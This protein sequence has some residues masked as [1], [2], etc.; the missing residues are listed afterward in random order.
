[1]VTSMFAACSKTAAPAPAAPAAPATPAAPAQPAA[2]DSG[3]FAGVT[4]LATPTNLSIG[5]LSGSNHGFMTYLIDKLGGYKQVG[6]TPKFTLFG[7]GPV[8]IEA[9]SSWD[10]GASGIGG[11]LAG[12]I[13]YGMYVIGETMHDNGTLQFFAPNDSPIVKAGQTISDTPGLYGTAE[14]WKGAEI[15]LPRGTTLEYAL[16]KGL[17]KFGLTEADVKLTQMDVSNV[18]TALMAGKCPVGG[19]FNNLPYAPDLNKLAKPVMKAT[20]LGVNLQACLFANPTAYNDPVKFEAIKKTVELYYKGIDWIYA[21]DANMNQ[22]CQWFLE[23]NQANGVKSTLYDCTQDL[24]DPGNKYFTLKEN[25][26]MY[27]QKSADG[28][29]TLAEQ[30]NYEPLMFFINAG[31]YKTTDADKFLGGY[32]KSEI[33]ES[34]YNKK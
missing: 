24:K 5:I 10:F 16:V 31:K 30:A 19:L 21:S 3:P 20:D 2:P 14:T 26:D 13:G 33:I 12:T 17:Q 7:N 27:T 15:Y 22:A 18:N 4:P 32:F 11:T 9:M 25:Y 8:L 1:M 6:I 34:I 28:K 23:W 29:M